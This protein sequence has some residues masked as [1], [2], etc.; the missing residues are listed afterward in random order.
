MDNRVHIQLTDEQQVQ[1]EEA[2]NTL[3]GILS[4]VLITLSADERKTLPKMGD[5]TEPFVE[6]VVDY[7]KTNPEY[8][9]PF[10]KADDMEVD[11]HSVQ[12]L[13]KTL[14]PLRQLVDQ[15][16]DTVMLAGSEAYVA[17]LS[18]Y[19]SVKL[20]QRM[21]QPGAGAIVDDLKKRFAG[22]GKKGEE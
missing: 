13:N 10:I 11:F 19:N 8:V 4:D 21:K 17:A 3:N 12:V 7:T 2:M 6:K 14:R 18:F 16:E 15:L 9:P 22:Q 5:N 1:L 20:A